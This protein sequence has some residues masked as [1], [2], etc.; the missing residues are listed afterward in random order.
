MSS[1][2]RCV[3]LAAAS[4]SGSCSSAN[5]ESAASSTMLEDFSKHAVRS[6]SI[7]LKTKKYDGTRRNKNGGLLSRNDL[8]HHCPLSPAALRCCANVLN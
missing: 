5:E 7:L 6:L 3:V 4:S 2:R 1:A 8:A